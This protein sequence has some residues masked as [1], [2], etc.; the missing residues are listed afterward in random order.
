MRI[1]IADD[2]LISRTMLAKSLEKRG[3]EIVSS[4]NGEQA[5]QILQD[6]DAPRLAI[7]DWMMPGLSGLDICRR[8]NQLSSDHPPYLIILTSKTDTDSLIFALESGANDFLS[9]PF[10]PGVLYARIAVGKRVVALQD[11]LYESREILAYQAT[12]DALTGL[13]NRR[14]IIDLLHKET[15]R[16]Q[17]N[18]QLFSIGVVDVDHFKHIND[19]FGHPIGDEVLRA[20]SQI[21]SS[22]LRSYE[23]VG[24]IG[25]EEFLII[26]PTAEL[27]ADNPLYERL[28]RLVEKNPILTAAGELPLN[29][30]IGVAQFSNG[31]HAD[32]LLSAADRAL[33]KA[34]SQGRNQVVYAPET[35]SERLF[36]R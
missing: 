27:C 32:I 21:I 26:S 13:L 29:I 20:L 1:L 16:A 7:L 15:I 31:A 18:N 5:W 10:D 35:F 33:Y 22:N 36:D 8:I 28:R 34:K 24:R 19:R 12:H 6:D 25:G 23:A 14:A 9:K 11:S 30:S 17:R 4:T 3:H 2:D